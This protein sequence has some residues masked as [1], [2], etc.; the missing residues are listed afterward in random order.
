MIFTVRGSTY[1][2]QTDEARTG[3]RCH[4]TYTLLQIHTSQSST[5]GKAVFKEQSRVMLRA[6][7]M[8]EL[9]DYIGR[10]AVMSGDEVR[11]VYE[12]TK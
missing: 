7:T 9:F 12:R 3:W 1:K 5:N 6:C 10:I 2:I 8:Q 11:E 4:E